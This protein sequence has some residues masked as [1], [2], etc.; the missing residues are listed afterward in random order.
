MR[1]FF[2]GTL[3]V[4]I[5]GCSGDDITDPDDIVFPAENVKFSLHVQPL[6]NISCNSYGCHGDGGQTKLTSWVG[7]RAL[8]VVNQP[9]DTNC[10][11]VNVVYGRQIHVWVDV[12]NNHRQGLKQ[13]VIEGAQNN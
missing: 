9:G 5:A 4:F 10:G 1:N 6:L 8:N 13:W 11:L 3:F 12:N 2:I 7:V